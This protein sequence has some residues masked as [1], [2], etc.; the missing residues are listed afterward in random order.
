MEASKAELRRQFDRYRTSLDEETYQSLSHAAIKNLV[1]VPEIHSAK[2]VHTYWP[3]LE[4]REIDTRPFIHWLKE[5]GKEI[6]LPVVLNFQRT[7]AGSKRLDHV[8]YPGEE[9]LRLNRWGIAEPVDHHSVPL[10]EIDAV[11]VP[12]FGA[13]RR[14]HRIGFG[15]G[16]YDEFLAGINAPTVALVYDDCLVDQLSTEEHDRP[17]DVIVTESRIHR[18]I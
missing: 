10:E 4:C 8:R 17:V 14:G 18:A 11:V 15:Y 16:Y 3:M 5:H 7:E 9:G 6:V 13:D 1:K 2:V 12:A